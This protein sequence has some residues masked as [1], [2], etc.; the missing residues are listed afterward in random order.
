MGLAAQACQLE[1]ADNSLCE[2]VR[3]RM[4]AARGHERALETMENVIEFTESREADDVDRT[5][6]EPFPPA[7]QWTVRKVTLFLVF[8]LGQ[9]LR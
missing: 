3:S 2:D 5:A 4:V 9:P 1:M 7:L 8:L 6:A